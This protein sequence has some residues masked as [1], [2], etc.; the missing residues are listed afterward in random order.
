VAAPVQAVVVVCKVGAAVPARM[1]ENLF[2]QQKDRSLQFV[3]QD[4]LVA[5]QLVVVNQDF[6]VM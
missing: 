5:A 3:Q 4:Q 1:Q 2:K 6:Q